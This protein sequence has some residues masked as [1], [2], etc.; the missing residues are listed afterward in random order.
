MFVGAVLF[1]GFVFGFALVF[2]TG[3]F[4]CHGCFCLSLFGWFVVLVGE[5]LCVFFLVFCFFGFFWFFAFFVC[6][7]WVLGCFVCFLLFCAFDGV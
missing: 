1:D 2:V 7:G 4:R 5:V 3:L 6:S